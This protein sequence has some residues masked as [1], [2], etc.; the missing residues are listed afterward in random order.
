MRTYA[1]YGQ[2]YVVCAR[3]TQQPNNRDV[4]WSLLF[5]TVF[6]FYPL[7]FWRPLTPF[8]PSRFACNTPSFLRYPIRLLLS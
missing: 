8:P 2:V 5:R 3:R 1:Y 7:R 6:G 4:S